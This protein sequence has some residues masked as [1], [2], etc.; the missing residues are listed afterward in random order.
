LQIA[1]CCFM[2][3]MLGTG[4]SYIKSYFGWNLIRFK[5]KSSGMRSD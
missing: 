1:C 5:E 4:T 2:Q 3:K